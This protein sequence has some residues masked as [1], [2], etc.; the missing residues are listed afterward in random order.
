MIQSDDLLTNIQINGSTDNYTLHFYKRRTILHSICCNDQIT[1]QFIHFI[2]H[3]ATV[4][5][6]SVLAL[7]WTVVATFW[8]NA[9]S[10]SWYIAMEIT[11]ECFLMIY[12]LVLILAC[13]KKV[14]LLITKE[15]DFWMKFYYAFGSMVANAIYIRCFDFDFYR[16]LYIDLSSVII[17]LVVVF[18]SLLEGLH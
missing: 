8:I 10:Y 5:V 13:N 17:L 18:F 14:F 7:L 16:I 11:F 3:K 6:V 4:L 2:L 12:L 1:D 15:F 9:R